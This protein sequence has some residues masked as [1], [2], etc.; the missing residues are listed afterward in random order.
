MSLMEQQKELPS[1]LQSF[2]D[3]MF[4]E[5]PFVSEFPAR[6]SHLAT[7]AL[8][9]YE[10]DGRYML[11]VSVPGYDPKDIAIEVNGNV[12]TVSGSHTESEEKKGAKF[13]RREIRTGSF[14]RSVSL[15]QDIDP[16]KVD[17]TINKGVLTVALSPSKPIAAKKIAIKSS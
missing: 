7:P 4:D 6:L 5:F 13:H 14:R 17:A 15:P 1:D 9:L 8:D 3:R 11:D 2:I 12:L 10:K 16:E